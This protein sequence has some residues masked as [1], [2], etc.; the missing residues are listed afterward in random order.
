MTGDLKKRLVREA[1]E[2][3]FDLCRVCRPDSVGHVPAGL[4]GFLEQGYHGQMGW[5]AERTHWRGDPA[6]LW[7]EAKSIIML[8]ESYTPRHDPTAVH[9][10]PDR[11]AISVY[12]QNKDYHDL[13]KKRLKRFLILSSA[14]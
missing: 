14:M 11:G 4:A 7:P 12:A 2:M 8:G 3:G 13:V 5:L 10:A 1:L 6:A 9:G